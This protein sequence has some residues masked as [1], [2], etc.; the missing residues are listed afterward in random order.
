MTADARNE[1]VLVILVEEE[2]DLRAVMAALLSDAGFSVAQAETTDAA[3]DLLSTSR[4][5]SGLVTDA[6][7]PGE[8]DGWELAHEV[9][10]RWPDLAV[11]LT[12]GHSD[13]TS[14]PLPEGAEFV[15][16]PDVV[17]DL[18]PMLRR[19]MIRA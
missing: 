3:L 1:A 7:V 18:V 4:Q 8:I 14:G 16:K 17:A 19:L 2:P 12:S 5:I 15:L 11:V 10:R 9:R 6:H 13:A